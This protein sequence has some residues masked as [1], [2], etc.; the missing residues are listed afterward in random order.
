MSEVKFKVFFF[1]ISGAVIA[2]NSVY[3]LIAKTFP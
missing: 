1:W 3:G 2:D